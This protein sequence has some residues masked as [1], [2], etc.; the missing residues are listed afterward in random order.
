[1]K[2]LK[3]IYEASVELADADQIGESRT[4]VFFFWMLLKQQFAIEYKFWKDM[5]K[6]GM[7][8]RNFLG[9]L[10]HHD[11]MRRVK[12]TRIYRK[13]WLPYIYWPI[14]HYV[15]AVTDWSLRI[16]AKLPGRK[17]YAACWSRDCDMYERSWASEYKNRWA[18]KYTVMHFMDDAEGAGGIHPISKQ[19]YDE[20]EPSHRDRVMEAFENGNGRSIYV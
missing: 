9:Y 1:M 17:F 2:S 5:K 13:F 8:R 14:R 4:V 15:Y 20:F 6:E 7:E 18:Y 3:N 16:L 11:V 12:K 10:W 19:E